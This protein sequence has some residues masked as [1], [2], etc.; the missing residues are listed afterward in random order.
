MADIYSDITIGWN[1][2]GCPPDQSEG[3]NLTE[4]KST[5][6]LELEENSV[7]TFENGNY[8][9]ST[10]LEPGRGYWVKVLS[11]LGT[12]SVRDLITLSSLFSQS[13]HLENN[14]KT[15]NAFLFKSYQGEKTFLVTTAHT[16]IQDPHSK[17]EIIADQI[18]CDRNTI[19]IDKI[20][21]SRYYDV[22]VVDLSLLDVSFNVTG[23][24]HEYDDNHLNPVIENVL[25]TFIDTGSNRV[26]TIKSNYV[27][28]VNANIYLGAITHKLIPGSSGSAV[29]DSNSKILGMITSCD[30]NYDNMTLVVPIKT[31]KHIINIIYNKPEGGNFDSQ[32]PIFPNLM[33]YSLGAGHLEFLREANIN[34]GEL[35]TYSINTNIKPFD[36]IT[37]YSNKSI[38]KNNK[39]CNQVLENISTN[40]NSSNVTIRK[41]SNNWRNNY[42]TLPH[43]ATYSKITVNTDNTYIYNPFIKLNRKV[44]D[45]KI[46]HIYFHSLFDFYIDIDGILQVGLLGIFSITAES[47]LFQAN[48]GTYQNIPILGGSGTGATATIETTVNEITSVTINNGGTGYEEGD[49]LY[50]LGEFVG[51]NT[52][53]IIIDNVSFTP[54]TGHTISKSDLDFLFL[55]NRMVIYTDEIN[56]DFTLLSITDVEYIDNTGVVI[57]NIEN[58]LSEID[59][60]SI[61]FNKNLNNLDE[62]YIFNNSEIYY[63]L[64]TDFKKNYIPF[65]ETIGLTDLRSVIGSSNLN[66][67]VQQT[68]FTLNIGSH[69]IGV[70]NL[71]NNDYKVL[72]ILFMVRY[73]IITFLKN[74]SGNIGKD[75][76]MWSNE[77]HKLI[78]ILKNHLTFEL[79]LNSDGEIYTPNDN[80]INHK[81]MFYDVSEIILLQIIN[82]VNYLSSRYMN[83]FW[84]IWINS[85]MAVNNF[86]IKLSIQKLNQ[87]YNLNSLNI[88]ENN[89]RVYGHK[90][91]YNINDGDINTFLS[92]SRIKKYNII[93]EQD[94]KWEAIVQESRVPYYDLISEE[95]ASLDLILTFGNITEGD[96]FF[97][98]DFNTQTD[99]Q[100]SNVTETSIFSSKDGLNNYNN[101][102]NLF[103]TKR[104]KPYISQTVD[105]VTTENDTIQQYELILKEIE[106]ILNGD[107]DITNGYQPRFFSALQSFWNHSHLTLAGIMNSI[108]SDT[109]TEDTTAELTTSGLSDKGYLSTWHFRRALQAG[110]CT[111]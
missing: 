51:R 30:D 39:L 101:N 76:I 84:Q 17:Y 89:Q 15:S 1:I 97:F 111:S 68:V 41:V 99:L 108:S 62:I 72:V 103:T 104:L 78:S 75:L 47:K 71:Y 24:P 95:K 73:W 19:N 12:H 20:W 61:L 3:I 105:N 43:Y 46:G 56:N 2:I 60:I 42:A 32:F 58:N 57:T 28:N 90:I 10:T 55:K 93:R 82:K 80:K 4:L 67:E 85:D 21:Y 49:E 74:L 23:T 94:N 35:V 63:D 33:T 16:I 107:L 52:S 70:I 102:A 13:T 66:W 88:I 59:S 64:V 7:W 5:Y 18:R 9:K 25:T 92:V 37:G 34:D 100:I 14:V 31:I 22:A 29:T 50:I 44:Q 83:I 98:L 65:S 6:G 96:N 87:K 11:N 40:S 54:E 91:E 79:Y 110:Q 8:I 81:N 27:S 36:I 53:K 109:Y 77:V 69:Q 106:S 26:I 86:S 45:F 48:P 38:G